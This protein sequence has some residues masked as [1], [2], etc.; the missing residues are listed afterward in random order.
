MVD[1]VEVTADP[2]EP[3]KGTAEYN[4]KM[5]KI[6]EGAINNGKGEAPKV[7]PKPNGIPDKFYNPETGE[8]DVEGLAK[9]YTELEKNRSKEVTKPPRVEPEAVKQTDKPSDKK[10]DGSDKE[11]AETVVESAGLDMASLS[12]EYATTGE[13]TADSYSKLEAVGITKDVVDA[14]I[15]GQNAII[16]EAKT[17]AFSLTGGEESYT[18][19]IE[20]AK[21]NLSEGEIKAYNNNVNSTD[22]GI[23]ETVIRGL[24]SRYQTEEGSGGDLVSGKTNASTKGSAYESNAQMMTDMNDPRYKTD[25]AFRKQVADKLSRS[26]LF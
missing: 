11:T 8:V 6:G 9:S 7:T 25:E 21:A 12:E 1:R 20:W 22:A 4:E 17:T 24:H 16:N 18:A 10:G 23:R 13:L 3:E 5:S 19:M 2:V 26:S 14:Y 15:T